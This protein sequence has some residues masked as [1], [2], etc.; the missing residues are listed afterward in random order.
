MAQEAYQ[1][2]KGK[3]SAMDYGS[4]TSTLQC[5]MCSPITMRSIKL[6]WK[7]KASTSCT[8]VT[9]RQHAQWPSERPIDLS[10]DKGWW[11]AECHCVALCR[12]CQHSSIPP[13]LGYCALLS[14]YTMV[15]PKITAINSQSHSPP[16]SDAVD[17]PDIV[18]LAINECV[19]L[20]RGIVASMSFDDPVCIWLEWQVGT[21]SK[22]L[23]PVRKERRL[24]HKSWRY[25]T[26]G[27]HRATHQLPTSNP[28]F[29]RKNQLFLFH[30]TTSYYILFLLFWG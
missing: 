25:I 1:K 27:Y 5:H 11:W 6:T 17:G 16:S 28:S 8:A 4:I 23:G 24:T 26:P 3:P 29:I 21:Q 18:R 12:A 14:V 22:I 13:I 20:A 9:V 7:A 15:Q 2:E 30:L 10:F 19:V